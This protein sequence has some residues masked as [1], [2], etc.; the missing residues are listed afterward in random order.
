MKLISFLERGYKPKI[1]LSVT[2]ASS[3]KGVNVT[4]LSS[5]VALQ[6]AGKCACAN[7]SATSAEKN[8]TINLF[9]LAS[10]SDD[11]TILLII[12]I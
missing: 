11:F 7:P 3:F 9:P 1:D 10:Y 12:K 8:S 5:I 4:T 2:F 6:P